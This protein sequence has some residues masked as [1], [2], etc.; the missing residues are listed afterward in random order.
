MKTKY[1][2]IKKQGNFVLLRVDNPNRT[3]KHFQIRV[4]NTFIMYKT[5]IN[6]YL[7]DYKIDANDYDFV[8]KFKTL[9]LAEKY[10][11]MCLLK[12]DL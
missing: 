5:D 2:E 4:I 9:K 6:Q 12:Y 8:Y 11:T 10:Y 1:T 7:K 3:R